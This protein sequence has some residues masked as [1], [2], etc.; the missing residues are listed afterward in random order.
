[1]RGTAREEALE[2]ASDDEPIE[3][4][5]DRRRLAARFRERLESRLAGKPTALVVVDL[6]KEGCDTP[7]AQHKASGL[8]LDD[9]REARRCVF[10]HAEIVKKELGLELENEEDGSEEVFQ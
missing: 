7:L 10:Y 9:L 8:S 5:L 1:M 4:V 6:M 2:I 3:D